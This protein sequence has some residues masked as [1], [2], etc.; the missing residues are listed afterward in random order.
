[1]RFHL[2]RFRSVFPMMRGYLA[3]LLPEQVRAYDTF[4]ARIGPDCMY[5]R[6]ALKVLFVEANHRDGERFRQSLRERGYG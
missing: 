4:V 6:A 2:E 1:M 5:A 3:D